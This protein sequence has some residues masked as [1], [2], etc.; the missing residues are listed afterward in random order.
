[1]VEQKIKG[2]IVQ[3]SSQA[4]LIY[5]P[6]HVVYSTTKAALDNLTKS[7]ACE[8][9]PHGIRVNAINPT[10]VMTELAKR[11]WGDPDRA[12]TMLSRIP[13]GQFADLD[14][15]VKAVAYLLSDDSKMITGTCLPIDGGACAM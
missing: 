6:Q 11:F 15:V 2:S 7:M 4:S 5:L 10:V 9:G 13:L 3:V 8:L 12:K 1:M 14:D